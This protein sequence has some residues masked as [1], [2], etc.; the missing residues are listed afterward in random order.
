MLVRL[1]YASRAADSV[2][3]DALGAIQRRFAGWAMGIDR[4]SVV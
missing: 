3:T 4:K 2:S 1:M